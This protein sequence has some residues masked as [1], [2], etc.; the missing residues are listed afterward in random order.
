[1][2]NGIDQTP[3][4]EALRTQIAR[5]L[6]PVKPLVLTRWLAG[7]L[8]L[9]APL[10]GLLLWYRFGLRGE[11]GVLDSLWLW[12]L[13]GAELLLGYAVLIWILREA[14]PG[15][16]LDTV[17]LRVVAG[18]ALLLHVLITLVTYAKSPLEVPAGHGWMYG[19]Y[20]FRFEVLIGGAC[21]LFILWLSRQ[22]LTTHPR[23]I[24]LMGGLGAGLV[25]DAIWRLVCPYSDHHHSFGSHTSAI[26]T[27]VVV[28]GALALG[29]ES[30]RA[31]HLRGRSRG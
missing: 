27:L 16:R 30:W 10:S 23:R 28:G 29:W 13:S 31:R 5:D 1:M 7:F 8:L 18:A 4:F 15:R 20:C 24:G 9:F 19:L 6:R 22:G 12:G 21:L 17:G 2:S 26:L 3:A 25:A 14:V 11:N